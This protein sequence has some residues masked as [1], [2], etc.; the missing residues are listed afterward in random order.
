[1]TRKRNAPALAERESV[2]CRLLA[3]GD[4]DANSTT[5]LRVQFLTRAGLTIDRAALLSSIAF[6]EAAHG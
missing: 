1:M 6:G 3:G 2:E 4:I 5:R